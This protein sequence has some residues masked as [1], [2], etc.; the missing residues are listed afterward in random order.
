[1]SANTPDHMTAI[2][3]IAMIGYDQSPTAVVN[4]DSSSVAN[5]PALAGATRSVWNRMAAP[6]TAKLSARTI[7]STQPNARSCRAAAASIPIP[8]VRLFSRAHIEMKMAP[9]SGIGIHPVMAIANDVNSRLG[10]MLATTS[11]PLLPSSGMAMI[12]ASTVSTENASTRIF[13]IRSALR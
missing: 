7:V 3:A 6:I 5:A 4:R 13:T 12:V 11:R 1:M 2:A 9:V 10:A 8:L